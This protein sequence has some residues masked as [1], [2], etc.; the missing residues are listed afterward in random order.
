M[1]KLTDKMRISNE[2]RVGI[3]GIITIAVLFWGINYLKGRNIF[4]ST[5]TVY[6]FFPE[7]G[8][9]EASSPV[10]INGV[11]VGYIDKLQ[12]RIDKSPPIMVSLIIESKYQIGK[13]SFAELI[14]ADLLGTKV[15]RI[16]PSGQQERIANLDTIPGKFEQDMISSLQSSLNPVLDKIEKLAT[17]LDSLSGHMN[18]ILSEDALFQIIDNIEELTSA[19]NKTLNDGGSLHNSIRSIESFTGVL[20]E[21]KEEMSSIIRNLDKLTS[22]LNEAGLDSLST[23]MTTTFA[24]LNTLLDQLNSGEGTG[25][26][27]LYSDS[28]YYNINVLVENLDSLARDLK[29]NPEDYIQ[30]SVFGKKKK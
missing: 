1:K 13:G 9:L 5:Y 16:V 2:A 3:I 28:L 27:L 24:Q 29:E 11:K 30:V 23:E 21:E 6:S 20:E 26:K 8:G 19:L 18:A 15:I 22:S 17:S 7:S 14:S 25:G 10:I 4:N 12:L